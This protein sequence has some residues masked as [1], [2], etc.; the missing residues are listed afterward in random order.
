MFLK[1]IIGFNSINRNETIEN[2][3]INLWQMV[4]ERA[5]ISW[6]REIARMLT[7]FALARSGISNKTQYGGRTSIPY[8]TLKPF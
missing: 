3:I 5:R 7:K 2:L 6:H 4:L 1:L 8:K